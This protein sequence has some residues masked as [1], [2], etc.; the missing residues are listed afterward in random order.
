MFDHVRKP[1]LYYYALFLCRKDLLRIFA[2]LM[3]TQNVLR[4]PKML[5]DPFNVKHC[6]KF[7]NH[8]LHVCIA[9][10][11]GTTGGGDINANNSVMMALMSPTLAVMIG[12]HAT[13]SWVVL[14][15]AIHC[16]GAQINHYFS[17]AYWRIIKGYTFIMTLLKVHCGQQP[18]HTIIVNIC[19]QCM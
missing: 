8:C 3:F 7:I 18:S 11:C 16:Q 13:C 10:Q 9:V 14:C 4:Y 12:L 6:R 19:F 2:Y 17:A 5:K 1:L 15:D